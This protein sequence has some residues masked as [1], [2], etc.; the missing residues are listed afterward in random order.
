MEEIDEQN[1]QLSSLQIQELVDLLE[2][3]AAIEVE[4]QVEKALEKE[5]SNKAHASSSITE[6]EDK[7][8]SNEKL[9]IPKLPN[10][11]KAVPPSEEV[12]KSKSKVL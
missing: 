12:G 5:F 9:K 11:D 7:N 3:E 1:V 8:K 4:E 6:S 2:K 10:V